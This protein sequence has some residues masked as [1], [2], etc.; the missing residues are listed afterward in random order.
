LKTITTT[1]GRHTNRASPGNGNGHAPLTETIPIVQ[2]SPPDGPETSALNGVSQIPDCDSALE[3]QAV[4]GGESEQESVSG[5]PLS[6]PAWL[7]RH[8]E[9]M[10]ARRYDWP[11][12]AER[13]SERLKY[14]QSIAVDLLVFGMTVTDVAAQLGVNRGTVHRWHK[15]PIFL[16][17]LEARRSELADSMLDLQLLGSRIGTIKLLDLVESTNESFA[18]RA[19]TALVT[20]GH[21]AYQFIDQKKRFERLEDHLSIVGGLNA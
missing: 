12:E 20:S 11:V 6:L 16:A 8:R 14:N 10:P 7:A 4:P 15:D 19:A 2:V 18:L 3:A 9:R 13:P 5:A 21:R 17:E 1:N